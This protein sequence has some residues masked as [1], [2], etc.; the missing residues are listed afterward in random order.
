MY[1]FIYLLIEGEQ[2]SQHGCDVML[3]S[4]GLVGIGSYFDRLPPESI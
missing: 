2:K 1:L 4:T 3:P